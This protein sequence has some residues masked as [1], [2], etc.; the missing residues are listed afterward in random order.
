MEDILNLTRQD[1]VDHYKLY[2]EPNNAFIVMAGDFST[3]EML[4]KIKAAF[5]SIPRGS[6]PRR[7]EPK[8]CPSKANA[9][10]IEE[11]SG[12]SFVLMY[13]HTPNLKSRTATRLDVLSVVLAGAGVRGCTTIW[14][15][16]NA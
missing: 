14:F 4:P 9:G 11:R 15:I 2:Y 8:N 16:R 3:A 5:G 13:Y 7:C 1:L 10:Y 6:E 12:A